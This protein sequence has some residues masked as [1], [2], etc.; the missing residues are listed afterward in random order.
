LTFAI[1]F[2]Y[3]AVAHHTYFHENQSVKGDSTVD[4]KKKSSR[5][6]PQ[7]IWG[8]A[9]LLAGIGVFVRIPQVMPQLDQLGTF[10][11]AQGFIRFCFYLIGIILIGGGARKIF[12]Y[13]KA[14][15]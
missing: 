9:L 13:F 14:S 11:S 10:A 15:S 2:S 6:T 3:S 1:R 4:P 5:S 7:L 12:V 8:I